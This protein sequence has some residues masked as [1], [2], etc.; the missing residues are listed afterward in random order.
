[1]KKILS[2][3]LVIGLL[4]SVSVFPA[5]AVNASSLAGR[6]PTDEKKYCEATLES[7][8]AD[9]IVLVVINRSTSRKT[10]TFTRHDFQNLQIESV[11]SLTPHTENM[12]RQRTA[13]I[14]DFSINTDGFQKE[15]AEDLLNYEDF[16][17]ILEIKLDNPGKENVLMAVRELEKLDYIESAGPSYYRYPQSTTPNDPMYG[18]QQWALNSSAYLNM[19]AAW[20]ITTGSTAVKVGVMEAGVSTHSDLS[21]N[22]SS[23]WNF[24]NNNSSTTDTANGH[25]TAVA[26]VIGARGNNLT[27]ICG[28]N[29]K[30]SLVPLKVGTTTSNFLDHHVIAAINYA[31]SNSILIVNCS[32]GG[33]DYSPEVESAMRNYAGLIVCS[34]GNDGINTDGNTKFYP[35]C[36]N[37]SNIINVAGTAQNS[38]NLATTADWPANKASN[39]GATTVHLAAPGTGIAVTVPTAVDSTGYQ[40]G[41]W[42][43]SVACPMV[44]GVAALIKSKYPD[45]TAVQIKQAILSGVDKNSSLTSKVRSGGRLNAFNAL[46]NAAAYSGGKNKAVTG[47]FNNSGKMSTAYIVDKG[48]NQ[49]ALMMRYGSN[50]TATQAWI[51]KVGGF[52]YSAI[53]GVVTGKFFSSTYDDIAVIAKNSDQMTSIYCW[54][55]I[56]G[57]FQLRS[58]PG[59]DYMWRGPSFPS[60]GIR[61]IVVGNYLGGNDLSDIALFY[62]YGSTT[63]SMFVWKGDSTNN[64][65]QLI[66]QGTQTGGAMWRS[67]T[68]DASRI[69]KVVTG[70]FSNTTKWD[71]ALFYDH[72]AKTTSIFEWQWSAAQGK[73]VSIGSQQGGAVWRGTDFNAIGI[74]DAVAGRFTGSSYQD[75]ALFYDHGLN[76]S[77]IFE[78]KGTSTG[79]QVINGSN[80]NGSVW[81]STT[82]TASKLG[83]RLVAGNFKGSGNIYDSI[84]GFYDVGGSTTRL[85]AWHG[86]SGGGFNVLYGNGDWTSNTSGFD[87][88]CINNRIVSG[89]YNG[90]NYDVAVIY[91]ENNGSLKL[92][93]WNWDSRDSK[94]KRNANSVVFN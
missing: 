23:G 38:N 73:M 25:G 12:F 82:F 56:N 80:P 44:T 83:R 62:D 69:V 94:L 17:Q 61:D 29:W 66:P 60:S 28:V 24:V 5:P 79:L 20:D 2:I 16:R 7:D 50:T 59:R 27:G 84:A 9:D 71:I 63:T 87:P 86:K 8:F 43:T 58:V 57:V 14:E 53:I 15:E 3:A 90:T 32:F 52:P 68:F 72:G 76:T 11:K 51:S 42:G 26:G 47:V 74:H 18:Q 54:G 67:A 19:P 46:R 45:L 55:Y 65:Y 81:Q 92:Y 6:E 1:M 36:Y 49:I 85:F 77:S 37:L 70:K 88:Y 10:L 39:W 78:W 40:S 31:G 48:N 13:D 75:I 30:V 91:A 22:L 35:G 33:P 64:N 89:F 21:G 34:A 41:W 93:E 4:L